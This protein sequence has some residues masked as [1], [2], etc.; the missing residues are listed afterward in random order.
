MTAEVRPD[1][2]GVVKRAR[3]LRPVDEAAI[4]FAGPAAVS[5]FTGDWP[6]ANLGSQDADLAL[7]EKRCPC[8]AERSEGARTALTIVERHKW[9]IRDVAAALVQKRSLACAEI[10]AIFSRRS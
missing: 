3:F 8:P 6:L 4:C 5:L 10:T 9:A 2:S 1:G 7:A